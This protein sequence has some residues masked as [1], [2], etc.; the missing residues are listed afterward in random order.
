[1]H[2]L[3]S[4][5]S[6]IFHFMYQITNC[7]T[8]LLWEFKFA[9]IMHLKQRTVAIALFTFSLCINFIMSFIPRCHAIAALYSSAFKGHAVY[10]MFMNRNVHHTWIERIGACCG[11]L[12]GILARLIQKLVYIWFQNSFL[13]NAKLL[14]TKLNK[15]ILGYEG[16]ITVLNQNSRS[17]H[18][19][20]SLPFKQIQ[21]LLIFFI[22]NRFRNCQWRK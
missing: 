14:Q 15:E 18:K 20:L 22:I 17:D 4:I 2:N 16:C 6:Y 5:S 13:Y 10:I 7:P 19:R 21:S 9:R 8:I 1:M 11:H 3:A 12:E